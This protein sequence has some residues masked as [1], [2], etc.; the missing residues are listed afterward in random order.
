MYARLDSFEYQCSV[1][2]D[3]TWEALAITEAEESE[4]AS[5]FLRQ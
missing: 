2:L 4:V 3:C 1:G 5:W